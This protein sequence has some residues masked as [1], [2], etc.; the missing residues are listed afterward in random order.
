M[1]GKTLDNSVVV[2]FEASDLPPGNRY[3]AYLLTGKIEFMAPGVEQDRK[4]A[5]TASDVPFA[6]ES[7]PQARSKY[8][9]EETDV[10]KLVREYLVPAIK[11]GELPK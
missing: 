1:P 11:G 5:L 8:G 7:K 6:D 3:A 2:F 9:T 10:R 4:A